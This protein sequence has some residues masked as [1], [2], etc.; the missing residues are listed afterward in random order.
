MI[1]TLNRAVPFIV[2]RYKPRSRINLYS[3]GYSEGGGYSIWL[4]K[5]LQEGCY[6]TNLPKEIRLDGLY[7][8]KMSSGQEGAYDLKG[9]QIPFLTSNVGINYQNNRFDI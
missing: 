7:D 3:A 1:S 5:C 4:H 8:F 9:E 6:Y 2:T